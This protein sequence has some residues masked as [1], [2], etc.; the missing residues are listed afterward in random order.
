MGK[1]GAIHFVGVAGTGMS[2]L[3]QLRAM[4]G[5]T[6]TGSDRL[7][8]REA[9][10]DAGRRL[11]SAG[12]RLFAQDGS[13]VS[14]ATARVV[15]STAIEKDN[16]DL[17]RASE[18]GV[19]VVHRADELAALAAS[20]RCLAV[21][22]TSGKS[23]VTAM[24]FHI[25]SRA[26]RDPSLVAGAN[27][28][29]LRRRGLVGNAW[30]GGS[31]LL[32]IEADESDGTLTRYQPWLGLLL[33][34]SKDHKEM[35]ELLSLFGAFRSR[36][37]RFVVSADEPELSAFQKGAATFGFSGGDLRGEGL[38]LSASGSSFR[39]G[40][41]S[42]RLRVPGAHNAQNAL[43]A[44]AACR[45]TGVFPAESAAALET[46]EGVGRRFEL[47]GEAGGVRVIDD[48]AHNPQKVRAALAAAGLGARRVLAVFQL[49]G[50]AP[51]RFLK[52]EFV[53]AFSEGLRPQDILWLPEIYYAGGTASK[54]V[55]ARDYVA[56]IAARGRIVRY[57]AARDSI[58]PELGTEARPGDLVLVMGARDPSLGDFAARIL[59]EL[60]S[61]QQ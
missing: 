51:A 15:V 12:I 5:E 34:V 30:R 22:G 6:V 59:K 32:V 47:V 14:R 43:A 3:A 38:E 13:A 55:S 52:N 26:G 27:L 31:D 8:D 58:I 56:P 18:L 49:H 9:L 54:D 19:P 42:F 37:A 40:G 29:E 11:A 53:E 20:Q 23:T 16:L 61:R 45:E 41:A 25:L 2:A 4:A 33:N 17:R 21:A 60:E 24:V 46:F 10:G 48:F 1:A 28:P 50:F 36:S 39:A 35:P 57:A 7:A 44:A